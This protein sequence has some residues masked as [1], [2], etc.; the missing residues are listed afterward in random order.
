MDGL[1]RW[2]KKVGQRMVHWEKSGGG[3][4]GEEATCEG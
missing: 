3:K 1:R 2:D 4:G